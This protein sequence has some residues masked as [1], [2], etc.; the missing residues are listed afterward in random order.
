MVGNI[1]GTLERTR[2]IF[3]DA[4]PVIDAMVKAK[5]NPASVIKK[6]SNL[7]K[8]P[9]GGALNLLPKSVSTGPVMDNSCA[10]S[11]LP[12]LV[13]WPMDGGAFIT[14]PLVYTESPDGGGYKNSN[15]GMYRVQISGNEYESDECGLHYQIHRGSE[16]S[17]RG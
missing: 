7:L 11:D 8:L 3:R 14:L 17:Y 4:L 15:L 12:Q 6:P 9:K 10:L 13:S 2:F 16:S 1:F 5:L